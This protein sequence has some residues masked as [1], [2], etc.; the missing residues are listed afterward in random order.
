MILLG[1]N[2]KCVNGILEYFVIPTCGRTSTNERQIDEQNKVQERCKMYCYRKM[3]C[4]L[5]FETVAA[6]AGTMA[7]D[8][9]GTIAADDP[10]ATTT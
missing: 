3:H 8:P 9:A 2:L 6:T 4:Y 7:V 10:V 5:P 1:S